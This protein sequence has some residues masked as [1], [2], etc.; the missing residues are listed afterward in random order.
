MA[1]ADQYVGHVSVAR[2][3]L[4]RGMALLYLLAFLTVKNQ[5][6]PLLG[7]HGLSPIPAFLQRVRFRD[8]PSLFHWRYSDRLLDA[9]AWTG[10]VVAACA[11]L[12]LT[13][14]G[15]IW[16]SVTAWLLLYVLYLS[17][18][19]VGQRFF[20]FGWESMLLEAGFFTAFLGPTHIQPSVIPVLILRWML[21]R[22]ELG[23]GLIKLR[24]DRVWK[25]LTALYY[26]Y[27]TQ[28]LPNPLSWYF[29]RL[30]KASHRFGV[31]FSHF[32]QVVVPFGLFGPQPVAAI[33]A[34]LCTF[35]QIWLI[36]SGNYSWLNWLTAL[37]GIAGF[38]D[39]VLQH[40]L[41]LHLS[42]VAAPMPP[43]L[44]GLLYLLAVA[45]AALSVQPVL[46]LLSRQQKMNYSY[47]RY[48]LVNSYGAFGT[49][50]KERFEIVL[51]GTRDSVLTPATQW[52]EYGFKAKPGDVYRRPPQIAP[53][54]LRLDWMI[55]FLPFSVQVL[56]RGIY[57]S[58]HE[59]WFVR[60][61]QKLLRND[62]STLG[63]MGHNPFSEAPPT[64]I[65]A[66]FYW[67]RYT[68][69]QTK[70][71]T[72][73]WWTRELLGTYLPPVTLQHLREF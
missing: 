64:H 58:G 29:H 12:G 35:Q 51:E 13:E 71:S 45:V 15:P 48:H 38:S 14:A 59:L 7:E 22:T 70:R 26:H 41:P 63:L 43:A 36:V 37:L 24:G 6:K 25:D 57:V 18:Q 19:N 40:V 34:A 62:A 1:F 21:F 61:I 42:A 72:G 39:E 68:D 54:H 49:V 53:Y 5:G 56:P 67:Y 46:N 52:Q 33:A 44:H 3:V 17:V 16:L 2:L 4:Q 69:P 65:R 30:P 9:V 10:I 11:A 32:V 23:A 27:E 28:P 20:G 55:W 50:G 73:A 60:L 31:I 47:N 66:L 8:A